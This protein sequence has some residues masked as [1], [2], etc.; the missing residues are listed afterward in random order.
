[1]LMVLRIRFQ[2]YFP[3]IKIISSILSADYSDAAAG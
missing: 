3:A 2:P 1:M